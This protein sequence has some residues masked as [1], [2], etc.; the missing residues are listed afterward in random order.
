MS[1]LA[2]DAAQQYEEHRAQRHASILAAQRSQRFGAFLDQAADDDERALRYLAIE[3]DVR[4][5]VAA[6]CEESECPDTDAIYSAIEGH[7]AGGAF[8]DNCRRWK[9]G[10][11]A[12]CECDGEPTLMEDATSA[13]GTEALSS[14]T[15]SPYVNPDTGNTIPTG[16]E[17]GG[18]RGVTRPGTTHQC[19]NCGQGV[20]QLANDIQCPHCGKATM[21]V[22]P[23]FQKRLDSL[24]GRTAGPWGVPA[25]LPPVADPTAAP[26]ACVNCHGTGRDLGQRCA[27]CNGTGQET[28][29]E[30]G[31]AVPGAR[32][33]S[34]STGLSDKP[35][36]PK[37][38]K[39]KAGDEWSHKHRQINTDGGP[40]KTR[41]QDVA[42]PAD[43]TK[44]S[45]LDQTDQVAKH[46]ED[47]TKGTETSGET[48]PH[49]DT[50]QGKGGQADPVTSAKKPCGG[51][52][53]S[54]NCSSCKGEGCEKCGGSGTC[55]SC[56]GDGVNPVM[57]H[58]LTAT[59]V[60]EAIGLPPWGSDEHDALF[61]NQPPGTEPTHVPHDPFAD[62]DYQNREM[63]GLDP[64]ADAE[65]CPNCGASNDPH[66]PNCHHCLRPIQGGP[67]V[68]SEGEPPLYGD[69]QVPEYRPPGQK[70]PGI[71][72]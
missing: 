57:S 4:A 6:A 12:L 26:K 55:Q 38:D 31:G 59:Q 62:R 13:V 20:E 9:K 72:F 58:F 53:G 37:M 64:H 47:V 27:W 61:G 42:E 24:L 17:A 56:G 51:C 65:Y 32:A 52:K 30:F 41:H 23:G 10:P 11:K 1:F 14:R 48:G 66:D 15:A 44:D 5:V 8:C 35:S 40:Y 25:G 28:N 71:P 16:A 39:S 50:W 45:F 63:D 36:G 68:R 67:P 70:D 18:L 34:E 22:D 60:K 29:P 33:A 7:L 69:T 21:Q 54:G 3:H 46:G 49:T 43:Y 19:Q 2:V